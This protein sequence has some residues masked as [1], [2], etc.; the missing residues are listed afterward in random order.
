MKKSWVLVPR[1]LLKP[2]CN[3]TFIFIHLSK[4]FCVEFFVNKRFSSFLCRWKVT[5]LKV[6]VQLGDE[7]LW[8]RLI[9]QVLLL[10][11]VAHINYNQK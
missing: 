4:K 8:L 1:V 5:S 9:L 11:P 6:D 2:L 10:W 7:S 3:K